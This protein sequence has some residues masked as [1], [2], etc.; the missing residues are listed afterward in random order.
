MRAKSLTPISRFAFA[1]LTISPF[2][3]AQQGQPIA[4]YKLLTTIEIPGGLAGFDISWIDPGAARLYLADR[5]NATASPVI[6]PRIDVIDTEHDRYVNSINLPSAANGVVALPRAHEIWVGLN[7]STVAVINTD[8]NTITHIISTGGTARADEVA[9]DPADH[10]ILIANDR[11]TPP[12]VSFISS[13]NYSVV[14]KVNYDGIASP[15]STG[16]IEQPVWDGAAGK[17]YLAIPA[18]KAN[19]NGEVDELDPV[20]LSVTRTFPS[21]CKGPA[22]LVL[23]PS[24]RLMSS[25]GD[26]VDIATGKVLT[27]VKGVGGDEIWYN[28]GDQRVYFGGGTDR[29]SVSV[30][31]AS[32][33]NAMPVTSLVV[34]KILA[35]PAVSQTTHSVAVDPD[36]NHVFVAVA[37]AGIQV[38]RNGAS[39]ESNPNPITVGDM[40]NGMSRISWNAPNAESVEIRIGSPNGTLFAAGGNRGSANTGPWVSDG[41]AFFLQDVTGGKLLTADNTLASV[42]VHLRK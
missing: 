42:V 10:M 41:M 21:S 13:E 24:Q 25:C 40:F 22:G 33:A 27:T 6:P 31:D 37:G 3:L 14:K 5:G 15:E 7:D 2:V 4:G 36:N 19:P 11:D 34:G 28:P 35:A 23:I 39:I 29:I 17:F 26:V 1:L 38:W 18:T 20:S 9:Y 30:V 16:G 8:N 12:F 32:G